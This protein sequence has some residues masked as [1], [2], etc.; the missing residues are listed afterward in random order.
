M[1]VVQNQSGQFIRSV[2][3]G[4]DLVA[5]AIASKLD[6][7]IQQVRKIRIQLKASLRLDGSIVIAMET[8][9]AV[10]D[11]A[12]ELDKLVENCCDCFATSVPC[13]QRGATQA[14]WIT[15]SCVGIGWIAGV[16]RVPRKPSRFTGRDSSTLHRS[17]QKSTRTA[18]KRFRDDKR[19]MRWRFLLALFGNRAQ[20]WSNGRQSA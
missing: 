8:I 18:F 19:H 5:S 11:I 15:S 1:Y 14:F 3:F 9:V 16:R 2:K 10:A 4:S 17:W 6:L 12:A 20:P 13:I 7:E